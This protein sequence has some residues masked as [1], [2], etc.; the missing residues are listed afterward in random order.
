MADEKKTSIEDLFT[1]GVGIAFAVGALAFGIA[2]AALN[3]ERSRQIR[4]EV[5]GRMDD[6]GKR[7][8]ELSSQA[9]RA[10]DERKPE[11][12]ETIQKSR[13][14]VVDG[15]DRAKEMVEQ[16]AERAQSYVHRTND[17]A[18]SNG[19]GKHDEE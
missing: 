3:N 13:Q 2:A 11:I 1:K 5:Q 17:K 18:A 19:N 9:A 8:D 12:E 6:L 15:L 10:I 4:E 7:V 16:G 14:A